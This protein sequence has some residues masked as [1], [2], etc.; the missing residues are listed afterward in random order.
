LIFE[1]EISLAENILS[2]GSHQI[3]FDILK[4]CELGL[5]QAVN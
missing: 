5:L 4:I 2:L 1:I 3:N